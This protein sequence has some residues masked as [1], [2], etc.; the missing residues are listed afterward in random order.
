MRRGGLH[1]CLLIL[2]V[3]SVV[4][5]RAAEG[6]AYEKMVHARTSEALEKLQRDGDFEAADRA[7]SGI[8][9]EACLYAPGER[10]DAMREATFPLLLVRQLK[11]CDESERLGILKYL[12]AHTQL[13]EAMVFLA[14]P[15]QNNKSI[16][17]TLD[18]LRQERGDVL[19]QYASLTAAICVVHHGEYERRINENT[20]R[21]VGPVA[22]F[23]YYVKNESRMFF[24]IRNVPAELLE[25]VVDTTASVDDM[26]WAL[27]KFG[28]DRNIGHHFFDVPYDYDN[29]LH[30]TPKKITTLGFTLPNIL[31]YGGV[32]A[33]QAYFASEIAKAIG[34][35]SAYDWGS[36]GAVAHAWVGFLQS[37]G[38]NGWWNF[39]SGRYEEY[40]GVRGNVMDPA[41]RKDIPD[42][43]VSVLCE[44]IGTGAAQR[45]NSVALTDAASRLIEWGKDGESPA[46]T[47]P[48]ASDIRKT[49]RRAETADEL[50]LI[51]SALTQ[52]AG[53]SAAWFK[54]RDLA[55]DK[56]LTDAQKN[57]WADVLLR[58]GVKR[59]PD[60]T[61]AILTPM[62]QTIDD[63]NQQDRLWGSVLFP[64]F[65]NRFDLAASIRMNEAAMWNAHD[66][67]EKAGQL[68][69]DVINRY[70]NAGPFVI[71]AIKGA[72]KLLIHMQHPERVVAL[73]ASAWG[74]TK[75]PE[76]IAGV[77]A[78]ESNWYH[79]GKMYAR[80]LR[81]AGDS[82]KAEAVEA[83]LGQVTGQASP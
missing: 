32:C 19:E 82:A 26:N 38:R 45:Y 3:W 59:Y 74:N 24:G 22:I 79:V 8:F 1:L 2:A 31:K 6:V 60:F 9:D 77:F 76:Q 39:N 78:T 56:K 54:V 72:E 57:Q 43:Y 30:A 36:G 4:S 35:P 10:P 33:D 29:Y 28:G 81:E 69:M 68:Y 44:L 16:Y 18:T 67:P 37:D 47:P 13:A 83:K 53:N 5:V 62:I 70:A 65:Q 48:L 11:N 52:C 58:L 51:Q 55:T 61:L 63:P 64:M 73:Y 49:P 15:A 23:D 12:R 20:A 80:K 50:D 42:S 41:T 27:A 40:Q 75:P 17:H 25:Y 7:L 34:V 71:E 66:Q 46:I 14:H 21:S